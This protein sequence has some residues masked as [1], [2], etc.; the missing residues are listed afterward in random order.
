M[1]KQLLVVT[2]LVL[3]ACGE[4]GV[5]HSGEATVNHNVKVD[6]DLVTKYF[7]DYCAG[8]YP[9]SEELQEKCVADEVVRFLRIFE[10]ITKEHEN[11]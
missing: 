7:E 8:I 9:D 1:I 4:F 3:T 5:R 2:A 11:R 6:I 10:D